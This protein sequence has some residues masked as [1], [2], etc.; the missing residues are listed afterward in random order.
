VS[1]KRLPNFNFAVENPCRI[2]PMA[3]VIGQMAV[4]SLSSITEQRLAAMDDRTLLRRFAANRDEASFSEL[5]RRYVN[6]VWSAAYRV[7]G[8]SDTAS[9]VTQMVFIDLARKAGSLPEA[10]VLGGWLHRA[11]TFS[12]RKTLRT[13]QRRVARERA[14]MSD[15][16]QPFDGR[17]EKETLQ[18]LPLLDDALADLAEADRNAVV[19]RFFSRKSFRE[20][21]GALGLSD[22]A[23]Q[24]RLS[25]ALEKLRTYIKRRG[26]ETTVAGIT[27]AL[28]VAG[29]QAA[30]AGTVALVTGT[31]ISLSTASTPFVAGTLAFMKTP[32]FVS[33]ITIA[34]V[35]VPL[36]MQHQTLAGLRREIG[37]G[38]ASL[39]GG[40]PAE[41]VD[42][43]GD[44]FE[45]LRRDHEE[46]L[47]LRQEVA[48]LESSE[49]NT[50]RQRLIAAG[51]QQAAARQRAKQVEDELQAEAV[52]ARTINDLK[53]LGLAARIFATDNGEKFP[54]T[55]EDMKN[56]LAPSMQAELERFEFVPHARPITEAEPQLI[57]FREKQP[58]LLP[59]GTW[60][61][62]YTFADGSV[63]EKSSPD[64]NFEE[65]EKEFIAHE[66]AAS[67]KAQ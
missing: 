58:R 3:G 28:T 9:D 61:R 51:T 16:P 50:L 2:Q 56:E 40:A 22:D 35:S 60:A 29:A 15:P 49:L 4:E 54:K 19:L 11:A 38:T 26:A 24:K 7:T 33:L 34:A 66:P 6:L 20:I 57:L 18:L 17:E 23:A 37:S 14:A 64:G 42:P 45:R 1:G 52:R 62:A 39:P 27:G 8:D 46:L 44:E 48:T 32:L 65:W 67:G 47:Q 53:Q 31:V 12:A 36:V 59:D 21:G 55:F 43:R 10:V 25:R 41:V 5:T 63:Q 30:P 13:N